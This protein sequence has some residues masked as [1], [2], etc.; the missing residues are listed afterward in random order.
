MLNILRLMTNSDFQVGGRVLNLRK[1]LATH[2]KIEA[3]SEDKKW[4][5]KAEIG[6]LLHLRLESRS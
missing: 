5:A 4:M 6:V 3:N 1:A 2:F